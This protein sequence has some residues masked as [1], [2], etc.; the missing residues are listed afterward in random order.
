MKWLDKNQNK[1]LTIIWSGIFLICLI[2]IFTDPVHAESSNSLPYY[3]NQNVPFEV[4]FTFEDVVNGAFNNPNYNITSTSGL[5]KDDIL[6]CENYLLIVNYYN[7]TYISFNYH[8]LIED[9]Y[10]ISLSNNNYDSFV[11]GTDYVN[12][13]FNGYGAN[14][15]KYITL[16]VVWNPEVY[17][18]QNGG[19]GYNNINTIKVFNSNNNYPLNYPIAIKKDF[20]IGNDNLVVLGNFSEPV[21]NTGH[22]TPPI[23]D[24]G[25]YIPNPN[26]VKPTINPYTP[27]T[28][29]FPNIDTSSL[30]KLLESLIDYVEYGFSYIGNLINGWFSNLINNISSWFDYVVE[31]FNRGFNNV[32]GSIQD[33]AND[34]Y[35]NMVSL[36]E[37][38]SSAIN[39]IGQPISGTVIYDNLINT[40]IITNYNFIVST[41]TGFQDGFTNL[42][43][44][45]EFKIPIH[46]EDLPSSYFGTLSTQYID[47]SVINPVKTIIRGFLWALVTYSL[48]VTIIDSIANYINGGGDE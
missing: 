30:E 43:E 8:V 23:N 25:H 27:P 21:I 18:W 19:F 16:S 45:N 35:N 2:I 38:V 13:T 34:F 5:T 7:P 24:Q 15:G 10:N 11:P 9:S 26:P 32:V 37:P 41:V 40:G 6:N 20:V 17:T 31:S 46:L 22:A 33:L 1:I 3:V 44:P 28:P 4:P 36:F 39:Y 42:S 29:Q 47:L 14:L 48:F 12:L